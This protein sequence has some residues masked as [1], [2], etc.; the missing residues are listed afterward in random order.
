MG[1]EMVGEELHF[2]DIENIQG[3]VARECCPPK[4]KKN[5]QKKGIKV[6]KKDSLPKQR[7]VSLAQRKKHK[8]K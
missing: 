6:E 4:E 2:K 8:R 1:K 5:S 3:F 7:K